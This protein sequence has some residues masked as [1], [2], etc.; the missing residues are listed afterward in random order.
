MNKETNNNITTL[1]DSIRNASQRKIVETGIAY[2]EAD[3]IV[4]KLRGFEQSLTDPQL[5]H[6][7]K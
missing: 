5:W 2:T 6:R 3:T 7:W 4:F 1:I